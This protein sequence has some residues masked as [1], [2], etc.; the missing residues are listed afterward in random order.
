MLGAGALGQF[1]LGQATPALAI[2]SAAKDTFDGPPPSFLAWARKEKN[3]V[4]ERVRSEKE[5]AAKLKEVAQV[6]I[7]APASP[8]KAA[9]GVVLE[10]IQKPEPDFALLMLQLEQVQAMLML[11]NRIKQEQEVLLLLMEG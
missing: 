9:V 10:A 6:V 8:E 5:A 2:A 3:K 7:Q 1:A 4:L 11:Y